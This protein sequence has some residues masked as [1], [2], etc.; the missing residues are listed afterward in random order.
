LKGDDMKWISVLLGLAL[1]Y[2]AV[3]QRVTVRGKDVLGADYTKE[4][5]VSTNT[6]IGFDAQALPV[7]RPYVPNN[8][9]TNA[10]PVV[11]GATNISSNTNGWPTVVA[12]PT[13]MFF[14]TWPTSPE[15][16]FRPAYAVVGGAI[17]SQLISVTN[18]GTTT[19]GNTNAVMP[20]G[21]FSIPGTFVECK[22]SGRLADNAEA[23]LIT[24]SYGGTPLIS[25]TSTNS[26]DW[27]A[28]W[29]IMCT[30][31]NA[32]KA[33]SKLYFGNFATNATPFVQVA[34][35]AAEDIGN[36]LAVE[37]GGTTP[38]NTILDTFTIKYYPAPLQLF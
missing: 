26:G 23:K 37:I 14:R 10:N 16:N 7:L 9:T 27:F 6:V 24:I 32:Q 17:Y 20:A 22:A 1:T 38:G 28:E 4:L 21:A 13:N 12:T 15:A 29:Q 35:T 2:S 18:S 19:V 11:S 36:A 5:A 25:V 34:T 31:T 30:A 3:A 8:F 33:W